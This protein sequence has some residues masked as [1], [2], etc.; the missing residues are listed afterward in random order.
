[1][2]SKQYQD[3]W[4]KRVGEGTA[5]ID[6]HKDYEELE[7][8]YFL[9]AVKGLKLS[10]KTVID[11]GCGGGQFGKFLDK[12]VR[13][14]KQYI[15]IDISN[16][17]LN[18]ARTLLGKAVVLMKIDPYEF[19]DLSILKA[20][21]LFCMN[22]IQHFPTKEYLDRWIE[23]INKSGIGHIILQYRPGP[24]KFSENPY[25]TT[26]EI[27]MANT[28]PGKYITD[29]LSNY[30]F[31]NLNNIPGWVFGKVE[32]AKGGIY[33]GKSLLGANGHE[34]SIPVS[35]EVKVTSGFEVKTP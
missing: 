30:K 2:N 23:N 35:S 3:A 9:P 34:H 15:G 5:H 17:S 12:T 26:H 31:K 33:T 19:P 7:R 16:R 21:F 29:C 6:G 18:A 24:L 20:D 13:G 27:N 4:D 10:K 25:K 22:V 8:D 1:M 32:F 11:Y 14:L 28:V